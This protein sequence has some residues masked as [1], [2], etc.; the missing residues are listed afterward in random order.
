ML[1]Q[2]L[3]KILACPA[4]HGDIK[5]EEKP[6]EQLTCVKCKRVYEVRDGI[7]IMLVDEEPSTKK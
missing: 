1:D 5:Y 2:E 6:K 7:P 4:C 3:L